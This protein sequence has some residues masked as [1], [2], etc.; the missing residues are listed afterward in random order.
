MSVMWKY[1]DKRAAV[2]HVLEDYEDMKFILDHTEEEVQAERVRMEG[3]GSPNMDGMPH[4]HNPQAG[5]DRIL[6]GLEKIDVLKER[7]RQAVE[8]MAWF[9]P[10]WEKMS[11]DEQYVLDA[12]YRQ[13]DYGA[14]AAKD[15]GEHLGIE[16]N[17]VYKKKNRALDHLVLLLYGKE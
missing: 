2:S 6:D 3:I 7:Y 5:E 17:S 16:R 15:V 8:Y 12:F 9:Q 1:L 10:A 11:E 4:A 13:N 14:E